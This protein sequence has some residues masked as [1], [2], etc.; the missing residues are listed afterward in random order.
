MLK[1][2]VVIGGALLLTACAGPARI[3]LDAA[4]RSEI[5][6]VEV[7]NAVWQDEIVVRA[8]ASGAAAAVGGLLGAFIESK[9][10]ESRQDTIQGDVDS[11]YAS[12]DNVNYRA[13]LDQALNEG[14]KG[15]TAVP[16]ANIK[17]TPVSLTRTDL[18]NLRKQLAKDAGFMYV[19]SNL[20]LT[21]D[22]RRLDIT[23]GADIFQGGKDKPVY[24]NIYYYQSAPIGDGGPASLAKWAA[25]GG[26]AY[27][28]ALQEGVQ[29]IARMM[30]LDSEAAATEPAG[31]P[32]VKL[33]RIGTGITQEVQGPVLEE[34]NGRV[35]ARAADGRLHSLVK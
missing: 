27:R 6:Q 31:A 7:T 32:T 4:A 25:D 33:V 10:A 1:S 2:L 13:M 11:L 34:V 15:S 19:G 23:A 18:E 30:R 24:S 17:T 35:I 26:A 9:V 16:V 21:S 12:I 5:K 8:E 20:T 22:Y 29:Q 3:A 28:K 14:F